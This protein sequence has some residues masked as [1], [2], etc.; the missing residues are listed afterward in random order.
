[1]ELKVRLIF[2]KHRNFHPEQI[3]TQIPELNN[4]LAM[5]NLLKD[6]KAYILDNTH[7]RK[8]LERIIKEKARLE[9]LKDELKR[10]A[11]K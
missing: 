7:F 1:M 8:E 9:T 10:I 3:V 4:L 2:K 5:R 6:L 11:L